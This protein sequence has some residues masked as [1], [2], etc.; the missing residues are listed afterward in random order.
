MEPTSERDTQERKI[1][2]SVSRDK[3][4]NHA[5]IK[6]SRGYSL[7]VGTTRKNA[8]FYSKEKGYEMC[9][10]DVARRMIKDGIVHKVRDHPLGE[11]YELANVA[12]VVDPRRSTGAS[13][14]VDDDV[15]ALLNDLDVDAGS[16][17]VEPDEESGS[18]TEDA[19]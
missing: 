18:T 2:P 13:I 14:S 7:I 9:A 19:L 3:W 5:R 1:G 11:V 8:N 6:L 4:A 10:Y 15:E 12:D 17:S 16:L